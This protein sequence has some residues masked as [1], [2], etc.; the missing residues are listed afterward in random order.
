MPRYSLRSVLDWLRA[1]YPEGI[2]PKDHFALLSVLRRRLTDED[3]SEILD[4]SIATAHEHPQ[5]HVDY[6]TLRE[7]IAGVLHEEPTEADLERVTEQLVSGAGRWSPGTTRPS[8]TRIPSARHATITPPNRAELIGDASSS[9]RFDHRMVA[10]RISGRRTRTGLR[11][12][13]GTPETA[14]VRRRGRSGC[15]YPHRG[16]DLPVSKTDIAVL[17]TKITNEMPLARDIDRVRVHLEAGGW[18]L[19]GHDQ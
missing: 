1:G 4:L 6:D 19:M 15:R 8:T 18:P 10:R 3:I 7:I 16:G 13:V 12:A 9:P 2:P 11:A 17:I 5:R 14:T